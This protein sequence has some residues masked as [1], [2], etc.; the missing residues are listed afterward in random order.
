MGGPGWAWH[1]KQ[2]DQ[3]AEAACELADAA[4]GSGWSAAAVDDALVTIDTLANALAQVD[5]E[6]R[7][8]L[9][10]V[11]AATA[12]A[13]RRFGL[14]VEPDPAPAGTERVSGPR[15]ARRPRP[16]RR[17]RGSGFQGIR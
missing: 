3:L 17:G 9:A 10:A 5:P 6:V 14:P 4:A 7:E 2:A 1:Q 8:V 12:T 11:T 16:R 13:R 15:P